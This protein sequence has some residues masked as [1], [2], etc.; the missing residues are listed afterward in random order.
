VAVT[1]I[2][3]SNF[4]TVFPVYNLVPPGGVPAQFGF[5]FQN[6]VGIISA[7]LGPG[8]GY[9]LSAKLRNLN[10]LS[11]INSSVTLWGV[12]ADP[13]HDSERSA[14]CL[15]SGGTCPS[16]APPKPFLTMPTSCG[17]PFAA[18][19]GMDSWE[20][21]GVLAKGSFETTDSKG[22]PLPI[23]GCN[24]LDFNPEIEARPTT[25]LADSPSG[26][27]FHLQI[28]QNEEPAGDATSHLK[29]AVVTLPEGLLVNPSSA[30]G[31]GACTEAEIGLESEEAPS[32]P[33]ASKLG[34]V[35]VKTPLLEEPLHGAV[36][37]A[38]PFENPSNSLLAGYIVAEGSGVRVKLPGKFETDPK[39]GRITASFKENPQLPFEDFELHFFGGARGA[40]RTPPTC[41][42][43]ETTSDLTPWSSPELAD[44][45]PSDS[46]EVS[47]AANG[48]PCP[49]A[50]AAEPHA[51]HFSAGTLDPS[52]G[53]FSP[54]VLKLSREDGSQ[55]LK[56]LD[57]T[58]PPGLSGKL[59]GVAYC[60]EAALEAAKAKSGS[61]EKQSPSC[62]L[63][64]QVGTV[65]VG[66]G[67]GPTPYYAQGHAYLT[68]P[69]KGAPLSLAIITPAVAGPF[70][71]GT[72]V[73][74]TA[75]YVNPETA[76]IHAVSD[77]IP[78]ILDGIPLDLRSIAVSMDRSQFTLNPTNCNPMAVTASALSLL[79]QSAA[80]SNRFQ[81]GGCSALGFKPKLKI[82]LEGATKRAGT[83]AL[84]A[85]LTARPGDANIARATVSLPHSEFLDNAHIKTICTRV[86]FAADE[87]P[88]DSVY[89]IAKATTPLLEGPLEGPVYLRSSSNKLPDL[90]ADLGGQI[91]V[92]L[93]G[94]IDS[95]H[96]GI[97]NTF[98][99]V[100]DA[101]VSKFT[102]SMKGGAKGLLENSTDLC[103]SPH[104][105]TVRL[106][107]QNGKA[108]DFNPAVIA[109]GCKH[110]KK[111][112]HKH[113]GRGHHRKHHG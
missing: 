87:C 81:V 38:K 22:N 53:A 96:G 26:L 25:N 33:D 106:T 64:S 3:S 88:A 51:P 24:A 91:Q 104:L 111:K 85:T 19:S 18:T 30:D 52:A 59:A 37:L 113:R 21:P 77:P 10:E 97:R 16:D 82:S 89:G 76:Q 11:I 92:V 109:T 79:G 39:T 15:S 61:E 80:L 8:P 36:Y 4:T 20:T 78:T 101:P 71:L 2:G 108:D 56:G 34:T 63:A 17:E 13:S 5:A 68:G 58:L 93:D 6:Q 60:P 43:F 45:E 86:Q 103:A 72:V 65:N 95:V 40:L 74:R 69:Y 47:A 23:T 90:V 112:Q 35:E 70:D 57:A 107:A 75:L 28:P 14:A 94:R 44:A 50:P 99:V 55:E 46:F 73:V 42:A 31:L 29:D 48:G 105:A 27:D 1:T 41:G 49:K 102:L 66:A 54:F 100:P 7:S 110:Q 32:C 83:P 84:I 12:P 98:E 62:P 67:A 9:R